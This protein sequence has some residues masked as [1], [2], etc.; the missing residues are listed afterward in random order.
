M[1]NI[2]E[3]IK[4]FKGKSVLLLGHKNA[5]PDSVCSIIAL[6]IGLKQLGF[7]VRSGV[8][9]S[10][11]KI[12]QKILDEIDESIEI[13]PDLKTDLIVMLDMS[14]EGQLSDFVQE[15]FS[16]SAKKMII[17]HHAIHD[18]TLKT[19]F[20]FIDEKANSTV[21]LVYDLLNEL[22]VNI[23]EKIAKAIL[24]GTV[25]ETAHLHYASLKNFEIIAELMKKFSIDYQ[26][27]LATLETPLDVSERIARLKAAQRAKFERI[28][29]F[30]VV[31]S[32]VKSFEASAARLL[33]RAGADL[34]GVA[35]EKENEVRIS[36]RSTPNFYKKT[37]IDL[38][39][40]LVPEIAKI[41]KGT[42]S[43]HPTAAGA[44]GTLVNKADEA[45]KYIVEYTKTR[46]SSIKK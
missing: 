15:I 16:S 22:K 9:E 14:T 12:S 17:D 3:V 18:Y 42:G 38:G 4:Q 11:S 24:L 43:G 33:I 21:E 34:A 30:L 5:D 35:A 29:D 28:G 7:K 46:L 20:H 8:V 37:K 41:I 25:A 44:N 10:A 36:L 19:D 32:K 13:N 6:S 39:K 40:E 45:L 23:N 2:G 26:W 1:K 31:A 27:I